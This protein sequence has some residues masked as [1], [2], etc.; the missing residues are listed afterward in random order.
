MGNMFL[1]DLKASHNR[2]EA[3]GFDLL[4]PHLGKTIELMEF[5]DNNLLELPPIFEGCPKLKRLSLDYNPMISP[6]VSIL[7]EDMETIFKCVL[8]GPYRFYFHLYNH[9]C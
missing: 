5:S 6:P 9:F 3:L 7:G 1:I 8:R 2:L 4:V